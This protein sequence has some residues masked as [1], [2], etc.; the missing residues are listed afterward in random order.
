M[1][2][3]AVFTFDP[4]PTNTTIGIYVH[5]NGGPESA[6]AF[7]KA[8]DALAVRA[9]SC[10]E[11]GRAVQMIGNYFG[12]T[13]SLGCVTLREASKMGLDNGVI[14]ITRGKGEPEI[15]QCL[16]WKPKADFIVIHTELLQNHPYNKEGALVN[17]ILEKNK[18]FKEK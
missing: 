6:Y 15:A 14:R 5:W 1:G 10:Y 18:M 11:V 17:D 12:G 2:N 13:L 9:D 4:K 7:A 8:M 3:H 16:D